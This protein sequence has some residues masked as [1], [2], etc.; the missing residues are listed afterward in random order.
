MRIHP[1]TDE[2]YMSLF[3]EFGGTFYPPRRCKADGE[4]ICDYDMIENYWFPSIPIFPVTEPE[5]SGTNMP[6]DVMPGIS[7]NADG[8][9]TVSNAAGAAL[10]IFNMQGIEVRHIQISDACHTLQPALAP[11]AYIARIG[12]R[13]LKFAI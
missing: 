4:L 7:V 3:H 8:S 9:I 13:S 1:E 11:G 2:I 5:N 12:R 6:A 10:H